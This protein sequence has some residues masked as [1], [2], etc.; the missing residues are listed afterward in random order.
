VSS[1]IPAF[2][3]LATKAFSARKTQHGS[4]FSRVK[5][6]AKSLYLDFLYPAK[7]IEEPLKQ[8]FG[9]DSAITDFSAG[10][11][12]GAKVGVTVTG[13]PSGEYI[14]T[15]YN[16]VGN[17]ELRHGYRH[18]LPKHRTTPIHIWEA[19]VYRTCSRQYTS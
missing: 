2:L 15:N 9:E 14:I 13:V 18:A 1:C 16:G 4:I 11:A 10:A 8:Q 12:R 3:K 6:L 7:N 19:C 17:E 5:V